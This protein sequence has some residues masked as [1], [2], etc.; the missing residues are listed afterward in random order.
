MMNDALLCM[1][2]SEMST[3][4]LTG[5]QSGAFDGVPQLDWLYVMAVVARYSIAR[6]TLPPSCTQRLTPYVHWF[7]VI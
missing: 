3:Q 5:F 7:E 1:H 4:Q 2:S 6:N